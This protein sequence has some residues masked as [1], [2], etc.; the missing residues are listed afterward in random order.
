[1]RAHSEALLLATILLVAAL[2]H[3]INMFGC[4]YYEHDEGHRMARAW[5][6]ISEGKLDPYGWTYDETPLSYPQLAGWVLLTG[7]FHTF[8]TAV[9]SGRAFMLLLQVLST[10]CLYGIARGL[11]GKAIIGAL[12]ALLFAL[13]PFAIYVHRVVYEDNIETFWMLASLLLLVSGRLSRRRLALSAGAMALSVLSKQVTAF[14]V[15]AFA[16]LVLYRVQGSH[17]RRWAVGWAALVSGLVSLWVL[18]AALRG[19]LFPGNHP[20]LV[21]GALW[22]LSRA[23]DGGLLDPSSAFWRMA[24]IWAREEPVLVV[25]G[26]SSGLLCLL[27][28]RRHPAAG[29]IALAAFSLWTFFGRGGVIA[30]YYL[31]PLLPLLALNLALACHMVASLLSDDRKMRKKLVRWLLAQDFRASLS[32]VPALILVVTG[33]APLAFMLGLAARSLASLIRGHPRAQ[34]RVRR[35]LLR[36]DRRVALAALVLLA[37]M[38][39]GYTRPFRT[40]HHFNLAQDPFLLWHD[41]QTAAQRDAIRWVTEHVPTG[42][43]LVVENFIWTDLHDGAHG[44]KVWHRAFPYIRVEHVPAIREAAFSNDWRTIDYLVGGRAILRFAFRERHPE[45][46]QPV[47]LAEA[48][49]HARIVAAFPNAAYPIQVWRVDKG[50]ER[51]KVNS[52]RLN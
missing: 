4:P 41:P 51:S 33:R 42:S 47:L 45:L 7:G 8:G 30:R 24:R 35:W 6:V 27:A 20:S 2:A 11:S 15:P 26:V 52:P 32:A 29:A 28:R 43:T 1:M 14:V 18:Y 37:L 34:R 13:S 40:V 48:L 12:A 49:K 5:S 10:F 46:A 50:G 36:G 23:R 38:A 16:L 17:R 19:E 25:G 3:G 44:G 9:D 22:Q 39:L 21:G 31:I